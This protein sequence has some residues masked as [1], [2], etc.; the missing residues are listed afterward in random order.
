MFEDQISQARDM[1]RRLETHIGLSS[2][3]FNALPEASKVRTE[4]TEGWG[5]V[6]RLAISEAFGPNSFEM[7]QWQ[8]TFDDHIKRGD[9]GPEGY[10]ALHARQ[11]AVLQELDGK[12]KLGKGRTPNIK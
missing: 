5:N 8:K 1:I 9:F 10:V 4:E 3:Q 7:Q 12:L 6:V 2:S 11:I